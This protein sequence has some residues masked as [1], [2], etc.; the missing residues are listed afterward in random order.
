MVVR[1]STASWFRQGLPCLGPHH[2]IGGSAGNEISVSPNIYPFLRGFLASAASYRPRPSGHRI[3][4]DG[5][6][7][8]HFRYTQCRP[9]N[10][11]LGLS[12]GCACWQLWLSLLVVPE[13]PHQCPSHWFCRAVHVPRFGGK[14]L[15][16][17]ANSSSLYNFNSLHWQPC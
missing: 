2:Q 1:W 3:S 4:G 9:N 12:R 15:R 7:I 17:S 6:W 14:P 8:S 11:P 10:C 16:R 5:N 13:R